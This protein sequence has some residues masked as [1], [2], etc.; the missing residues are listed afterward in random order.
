MFYVEVKRSRWTCIIFIITHL[1][2]FFKLFD[3]LLVLET[4]D[5]IA[6]VYFLS[7]K[8]LYFPPN[9]TEAKNQSSLFQF[10]FFFLLSPGDFEKIS[11]SQKLLYSTQGE[12]T[13]SLQHRDLRIFL[14][15]HVT[16]FRR[17]LTLT[18]AIH[19][20]WCAQPVQLVQESA[21]TFTTEQIKNVDCGQMC[22]VLN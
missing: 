17:P 1:N 12:I 7:S 16:V 15:L 19:H 14:S 11:V 6:S 13:F 8:M 20:P 4:L 18:E 9:E 22:G 21:S 2:F 5:N 3:Q 10:L